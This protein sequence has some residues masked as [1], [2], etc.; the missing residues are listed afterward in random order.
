MLLGKSVVISKVRPTTQVAFFGEFGA[1][2]N[3]LFSLFNQVG[4]SAFGLCVIC[5]SGC[6]EL[7]P[8]CSVRFL[9]L[10]VGGFF[11]FGSLFNNCWASLLR[12]IYS[13]VSRQ[14]S[15][16]C[17]RFMFWLFDLL[18]LCW[19]CRSFWFFL[20]GYFSSFFFVF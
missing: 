19:D 14:I 4:L 8:L 16:Y 6:V 10:K 15:F 2:P 7:S 17:L 3:L 18:F 5:V 11:Q 1:S 20:T 12:L 13:V 9:H